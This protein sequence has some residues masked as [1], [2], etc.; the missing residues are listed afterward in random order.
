LKGA[1]M[2]KCPYCSEDIQD[3][4]IKCR[5]CGE[6]L[7]T[8]ETL[9]TSEIPAFKKSALERNNKQKNIIWGQTARWAGIAVCILAI[10][11]ITDDFSKT[12]SLIRFLFLSFGTLSLVA[13]A[14]SLL[15]KKKRLAWTFFLCCASYFFLQDFVYGSFYLSFEA[16]AGDIGL[17]L[18][19]A[20]ECF[21]LLVGYW[22]LSD[23]EKNRENIIENNER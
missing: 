10:L 13:Y 8:N 20:L 5:Y 12:H 4:A 14:A 11:P 22:G 3:E 17:L 18:R 15:F 9:P 2:K 6:M 21:M 16:I 23:L 7:A 19:F 1:K